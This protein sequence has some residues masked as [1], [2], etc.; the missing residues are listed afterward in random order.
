MKWYEDPTVCEWLKSAGMKQEEPGRWFSDIRTFQDFEGGMVMT[1]TTLTK[2]PRFDIV[3]IIE[4][5]PPE[6]DNMSFIVRAI[7]S[8]TEEIKR[9]T[10]MLQDKGLAAVENR[11]VKN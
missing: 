10:K 6:E 1:T 7:K 2:D 9:R 3:T 11:G 5:G 4:A 8:H